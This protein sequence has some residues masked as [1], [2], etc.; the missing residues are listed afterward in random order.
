[1][2]YRFFS[3]IDQYSVNMI[4]WDQ[5]DFY[6]TIF[7]GET[8]I[9]SFLYQHPPHRQGI[10]F[11]IDRIILE[12][13]AWDNRWE[14]FFIGIIFLISML[15]FIKIKTKM[16]KHF[17]L[18]DL[19]IPLN[20][21]S[22]G[23]YEIINVPNPSHGS[24]PLLL[25]ILFSYTF[26]I[27]RIELRIFFQLVLNFLSIYTGFAFFIGILVIVYYLI[28][29]VRERTLNRTF[30]L[31]SF[32]FLVASLSLASFFIG[33]KFLPS[34]DCFKFPYNPI[35]HYL[36]FMGFQFS[37][38][39]GL[40]NHFLIG[41]LYISVCLFILCFALLKL[42]HVIKKKE[43]HFPNITLIIVLL[44]SFSILF[45]FNS[46]VGRVCTGISSGQA[47]RYFPYLVPSICGAYLFLLSLKKKAIKVIL[48]FFILS[49]T[50]SL[51]FIEKRYVDLDFLYYFYGKQEW[52]DCYL[53][54]NSA[55]ECNSRFKI[56]PV[57]NPIILSKLDYMKKNKLNLFKDDKS[58]LK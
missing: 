15:I 52:K 41:I 30:Y 36:Y 24:F 17:S 40:K 44:I 10:G 29:L 54:G 12:Q 48:L 9:K 33:Y 57:V 42:F 2:T 22:L 19:L 5:W 46:A 45:S 4:F 3:F 21:L 16:E 7:Q 20:F 23:F 58:D 34:V 47:S 27:K 39:L 11:V 26:F 25:I 31:Y 1:M 55:E 53:S 37:A 49:I 14:S 43:K 18:Y 6:S 13:S 38:F 56:Y 32:A 28:E 35:R 50:I 51:E 8:Y